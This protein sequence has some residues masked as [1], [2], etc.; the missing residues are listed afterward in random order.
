M[1][2]VVVCAVCECVC[3]CACEWCVCTVCVLRDCSPRRAAVQIRPAVLISAAAQ[4]RSDGGV[5][6]HANPFR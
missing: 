6:R 1:V 5:D 4:M 2:R 3:V